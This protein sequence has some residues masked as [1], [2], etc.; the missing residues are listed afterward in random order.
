MNNKKEEIN[1]EGQW[2]NREPRKTK[3]IGIGAIGHGPHRLSD[4]AVSHTTPPHFHNKRL[5]INK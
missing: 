5:I 2:K 3:T 1:I 4:V